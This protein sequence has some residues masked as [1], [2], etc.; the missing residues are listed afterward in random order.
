MLI[1]ITKSRSEEEGT[2]RNMCDV[3][4][5]KGGITSSAITTCVIRFI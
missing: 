2:E 1:F 5:P 4:V 3:V